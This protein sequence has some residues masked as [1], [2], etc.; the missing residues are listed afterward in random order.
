[1][2][3]SRRAAYTE[4]RTIQ[5]NKFGVLVTNT[6][7]VAMEYTGEWRCDGYDVCVGDKLI[8]HFVGYPTNEDILKNLDNQPT[9][10]GYTHNENPNLKKRP[11]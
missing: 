4:T 9:I 10:L 6:H 3:S 2:N 1:M 8:A 7:Y 5:G 11:Q